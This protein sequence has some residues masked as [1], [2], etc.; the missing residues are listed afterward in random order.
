MASSDRQHLIED[1]LA[2]YRQLLERRLPLGPQTID[3]IEQTVEEISQ[4]LERELEQRI[5]DQQPKPP[6]NRASCPHCGA[7]ARYRGLHERCLLTRHGERRLRRRYYYCAACQAG[8]AP[9]DLALGL[10]RSALTAQLRHQLAYLA[11]WQPFAEAAVT[12]Q[13]LTGLPVSA[14]TIERAAVAVGEAL[15]EARQRTATKHLQGRLS[16]PTARPRQLY[17][18]MDG[19]FVPLRDPWTRDGSLGE[20]SCRFGE[21]KVGAVYQ[22][23]PGEDGRLEAHGSVYTATLDGGTAFEP[24]IATLAHQQGHHFAREVIVLGDGAAWIWRIA[25]AQFP[26]AIEIIDFCHACQHL[27]K[28]AEAQF[29]RQSPDASAWVKQRKT[30][31]LKDEVTAVL[32][33][34]AAWAPA[35][36]EGQKLKQ[37]E[38]DYFAGNAERMRYGTFR[39]KGYQIASGVVESACKHVVASRLDQAGMHWRQETAEAIVCLRAAIRS[40]QAPDRRPDCL[41]AV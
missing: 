41:M 19:V 1:M 7:A 9:L 24:L 16:P 25:A 17:I 5:L 10:D 22:L 33:A 4:E 40:R 21:C 20:L 35:S 39:R 8:F 26:W 31:L 3:Q 28:I 2:R 11:A 12:L 29:G 18:S 32:K 36:E 27:W 37:T 38:Y 34:I 14:K 23:R 13:L 30:E 6:E 15:C